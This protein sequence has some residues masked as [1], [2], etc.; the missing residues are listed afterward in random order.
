MK[1]SVSVQEK[2]FDL[3]ILSRVLRASANDVGAIAS[4]VGCM[5]GSN[6]NGSLREMFLEHYPGMTERSIR[7]IVEAAGERWPIVA[8]SVVHRV[9]WIRP[10]EHIV[11]VGVASSHRGEAFQACEYI[12][13]YLKSRAPFWKKEVNEDGSGEW[14]DARDSDREALARW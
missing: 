12:M 1:V 2:D 5:R 10:G 8:C 3:A 13:D 7:E 9:G 6:A 4:F 14:V 11:F